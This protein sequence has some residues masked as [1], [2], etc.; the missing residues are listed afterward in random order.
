MC[1]LALSSVIG[2][3]IRSIYPR[4][5]IWYEKVF[6]STINPHL[7]TTEILG[8]NLSIL[9]SRSTGDA[10]SKI[11]H[12]V[13]VFLKPRFAE[14]KILNTDPVEEVVEPPR[15]MMK[16]DGKGFGNCYD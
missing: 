5:G 12:F 10:G 15:K 11:N 9:W 2:C 1:F 4:T 16:L 8:Q 14:S 13:P 7:K 3:E 6:R